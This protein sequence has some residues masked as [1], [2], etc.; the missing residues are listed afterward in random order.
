MFSDPDDLELAHQKLMQAL[1]ENDA[2]RMDAIARDCPGVVQPH[3]TWSQ[4]P[5]QVLVAKMHHWDLSPGLMDCMEV[6]LRHG[7]N[8]LQAHRYG[9]APLSTLL[10]R[11]IV[12]AIQRMHSLGVLPA[13]MKE[14]PPGFVF[15]KLNSSAT[16]RDR[17]GQY[18]IEELTRLFLEAGASLRSHDNTPVLYQ[19]LWN[20]HHSYGPPNPKGLQEAC[21]LLLEADP[22]AAIHN[23]QMIQAWRADF[24]DVAP[25]IY[26]RY[27]EQGGSMD[28]LMQAPQL[29]HQHPGELAKFQQWWLQHMTGQLTSEQATTPTRLRF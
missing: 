24:V 16:W 8:P 13:L 2:A 4:S 5:F 17:A 10:G 27:L 6:L 19:L 14:L 26:Q 28:A 11:G 20:A 7:A 1:Q 15:G 21:R 12:P 29:S 23:D 25:M 3:S 18:P 9:E 22:E